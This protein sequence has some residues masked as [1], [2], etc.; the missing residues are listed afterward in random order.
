MPYIQS[1]LDDIGIQYAKKEEL[2][3]F[4]Q[5]K[6]DGSFCSAGG[7]IGI[8]LNEKAKDKVL[9]YNPFVSTIHEMCHSAVDSS[10]ELKRQ[11]REF[12]S[13]HNALETEWTLDGH[14]LLYGKLDIP[15]PSPYCTFIR[16]KQKNHPEEELLSMFFTCLLSDTTLRNDMNATIRT[17][18]DF[19]R[20]YPDYF[21]GI[22]RIL[23][24]LKK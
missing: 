16:S 6:N 8:D 10:G 19:A 24:G 12:V 15:M 22:M 7:S 18:T 13:Q 4:T 1:I 20:L 17:G 11:L 23:R 14:K 2:S 9:A 3:V 21:N 5:T